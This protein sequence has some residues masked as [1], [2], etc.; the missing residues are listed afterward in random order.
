MSDT[1]ATLMFSRGSPHIPSSACR[2]SSG[3][4]PPKLSLKANAVED[5]LHLVCRRTAPIR[6]EAIRIP[7]LAE[8][9]ALIECDQRSPLEL[10]LFAPAVD[11]L[12]RPE[13]QDGRS[14][15]RDVVPEFSRWDDE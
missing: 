5:L 4:K 7:R 13:G 2:S 6:L 14:R 3:A 12:L 9:P 10:A 8:P 11:M 1:T 15:E